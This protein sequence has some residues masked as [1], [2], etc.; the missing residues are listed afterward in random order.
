MHGMRLAGHDAVDG[1]RHQHLDVSSWLEGDIGQGAP[2][3]LLAAR[4]RT[5]EI[6]SLAVS[7]R[8]KTVMRRDGRSAVWSTTRS[9]R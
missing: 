8:P 1:S 4:K 6:K 2:R 9:I 3:G 5:Q 7:F